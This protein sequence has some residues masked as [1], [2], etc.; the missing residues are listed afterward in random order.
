MSVHEKDSLLAE[1]VWRHDS[2]AVQ[3]A[4]NTYQANPFGNL[5]MLASTLYSFRER[6]ECRY[7]L[8]K[9]LPRLIGGARILI[10]QLEKEF[11]ETKAGQADTMSTILLYT[12]NLGEFLSQHLKNHQQMECEARAIAVA[13]EEMQA[14]RE[15]IFKLVEQLVLVGL[16]EECVEYPHTEALL[17]TTSAE[18]YPRIRK[19]LV[20]RAEKLV[21]EITDKNQL[22][23]VLKRLA[24]LRLEKFHPLGIWHL[25]RALTVKGSSKAVKLKILRFN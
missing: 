18:V 7:E 22:V 25:L 24:K 14:T 13:L 5:L 19:Q 15:S 3:L 12:G 10:S 16:K 6:D 8:V 21:P 20:R 17:C 4:R 1:L 23:R 11:T 2:R 9:L